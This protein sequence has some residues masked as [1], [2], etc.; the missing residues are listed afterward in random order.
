MSEATWDGCG[1]FVNL[2]DAVFANS[3]KEI[4]KQDAVGRLHAAQLLSHY[5]PYNAQIR[6]WDLYAQ[7]NELI[8]KPKPRQY[9]SK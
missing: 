2:P 9:I 8:Q 3:S 1:L 4:R 7:E 5:G 6:L